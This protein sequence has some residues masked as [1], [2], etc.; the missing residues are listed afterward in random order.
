MR[1]GALVLLVVALVASTA[2]AQPDDGFIGGTR[3]RLEIED[4]RPNDPS[5]SF[6]ELRARASEHYRRGQV[7][8]LQGDYDGAALEF[9]SSY[10]TIPSWQNLKN[11]GQS[12]ERSLE[13]E[14]AIAYF[15]RF[16]AALPPDAKPAQQ[17]D[18][19]PQSDKVLIARRVEVLKR[20][21]GHVYVESSPPGA[22]ITIGNETGTQASSSSGRVFDL[23]GGTYTMTVEMTGFEPHSQ[24]IGV[25]IGRPYTYFVKLQPQKGRLAVLVSPPDARI[26]VGDRLVGLGRYEEVL[27]SGTYSVSAEAPGFLTT[28]KEVEVLPDQI[29]RDLIEL[30]PVPQTGRRQLII[31]GGIGGAYAAGA[32]LFAFQNTGIVGVGTVIGGSVGLAGGYFGLPRDLSLGTSNLTI[33]G[34]VAAAIAGNMAATV[35]TDEQEIIQ[36]VAGASLLLGAGLG[37]YVGDR[38]KVKPGDAALFNSS[39][40][41]GTAAGGLFALSF[42]PPRSVAAGLVLSGMGLG[43]IGG[44]MLTNYF[45][46]SRTHALFVDIGGLIGIAGGLAIESLVY[47]QKTTSEEEAGRNQEHLANYA[48]GGMFVGLITAAVLTRNMDEPKIPVR[49]TIQSV[50]GTDGKQTNLYGIG[51]T[52]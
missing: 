3:V 8:Y 4:C 42:D 30:E 5:L 25:A 9:V 40:F 38:M 2:R 15:E 11:L 14:K 20:L 41:W 29:K 33:T 35:F 32:L 49:P 43:G 12:H 21:H 31:A 37:Y 7:L 23:L 51:G 16:L 52:W 22:K 46:I 18:P 50:T 17:C 13:Y 48:L 6:D 19:D 28:K 27:P 47:P 1:L 34:G 24:E 26:F 10:C 36:P 44:V 45:S 39:I